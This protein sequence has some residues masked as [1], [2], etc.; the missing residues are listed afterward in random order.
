M[1]KQNTPVCKKQEVAFD[2]LVRLLAGGIR[3]LEEDLI[4]TEKKTA[5]SPKR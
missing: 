4:S 1:S 5:V 3:R 2:K